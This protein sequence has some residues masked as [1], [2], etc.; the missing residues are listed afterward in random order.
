[1]KGRKM[2]RKPTSQSSGSAQVLTVKRISRQTMWR[3]GLMAVLLLVVLMFALFTAGSHPAHAAD[4]T[5]TP[6]AAPTAAPAPAA[7]APVADPGGLATGSG[8]DLMGIAPNNFAPVT[9]GAASDVV[10]K[11]N[12]AAYATAQKNEPFAV[13]LA[14][15]VRQNQLGINYV[16]TLVA[17]FLVMLMQLGFA[18]VETG[19]TR[20]KNAFHVMGMN[21]SVY[22]LGMLG[23]WICGFAFQFGG[24]GAS[25]LAPA[26]L[27]GLAPLNN[28]IS[29]GGW[30]IIGAHGFFL[31]G[32]SYDVG[33]AVM[34]LFQMVFMDTTATIPTGAMAERW[35]WSSFVIYSFFISMIVYPIFGNWVWGGGWL[36]QLGS[37]AGLGAG[38][39]DFAGSGVVHAIGGWT[40][41]AGAVVLG[42]RLGKYNKDGTSNSVPGHDMVLA[43]AGT[44][45]LAFGWFGFNPGSTLGAS[46]GGNLRIGIIAVNTMLAGSAGALVA[47]LITWYQGKR[48]D[49]GMTCNGLLAGLVAITAPSGFV[50]PISSIII[51]IVA[52]VLV[53]FFVGIVD[54]RFRIDDP[55]GAISVHG[56]NGMWGQLATGLFADGTAGYSSAKGLFYGDVGQFLAQVIGAATAFVWAFGASFVFFK[57]LGVVLKGNR[58]TEQMEIE[59]LDAGEMVQPGYMSSDPLADKY[60]LPASMGATPLA[61]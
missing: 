12:N 19:F 31:G 15:T 38:Y 9:P 32:D 53:V 20:Y 30:G 46:G 18:M 36:H 14:D 45:I 41:L 60:P 26:S 21:F 28:E 4:P 5:P 42:P 37:K 52:G 61:V 54:K 29:I 22:F 39:L 8:A 35:K 49:I 51:G 34:F 24:I 59:G 48:P 7:A 44:I 17:G 11:A 43:I 27:G 57:V 50:S 25:D 16:W 3:V 40:A 33:I 6:G 1:M 47:M 55:V 58:P 13:G 23:Y 2:L 10:L 56:V